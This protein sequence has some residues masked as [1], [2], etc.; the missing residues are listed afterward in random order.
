MSTAISHI[1]LEAVEADLVILKRKRDSQRE[2]LRALENVTPGPHSFD[3]TPLKRA[4][5]AQTLRECIVDLD[6]QIAGLESVRNAVLS[7]EAAK[8]D[9]ARIEAEW[10]EAQATCRKLKSKK[11]KDE[12][13]VLNLQTAR[14]FRMGQLEKATNLVNRHLDAKPTWDEY[15]TPTELEIYEMLSKR[16]AKEAEAARLASQE[17]EATHLEALREFQKLCVSLVNAIRHEELLR[18]KAGKA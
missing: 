8:S 4:S 15:P 2:T 7:S 13:R 6:R 3:R 18:T 1:S 9:R 12:V 11:E 16:Y 10:L 17:A 5:E 14:E